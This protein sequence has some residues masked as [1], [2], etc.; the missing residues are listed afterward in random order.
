[1]NVSL[2]DNG[3]I[4][5]ATFLHRPENAKDVSRLIVQHNLPRSFETDSILID[6]KSALTTLGREAVRNFIL[7][8]CSEYMH[9]T[10]VTDIYDSNLVSE[11][12]ELLKLVHVHTHR[13]VKINDD[14]I[15]QQVDMEILK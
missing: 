14:G 5:R 12:L 10:I 15:L 1:M 3:L 6:G 9:F 2:T 4:P 8:V 11:Y 7:N 13:L